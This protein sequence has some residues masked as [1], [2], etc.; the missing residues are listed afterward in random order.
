MNRFFGMTLAALALV[1]FASMAQAEDK[2]VENPTGVFVSS[3]AGKI[4]IKQHA[5]E[6]TYDLATNVK[7]MVKGKEGKIAD[8]KAGDA[9]KLT[10]TDGK[11]SA[12]EAVEPKPKAKI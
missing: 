1:A 11:V 12:V 10:M 6:K 2:K 4:T 3:T 7:V 9:L 5:E 8:L